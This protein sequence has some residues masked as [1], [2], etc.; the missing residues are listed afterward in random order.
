MRLKN[1]LAQFA[2]G[3]SNGFW[4]SRFFASAAERAQAL[5]EFMALRCSLVQTLRLDTTPSPQSRCSFSVSR[6]PQ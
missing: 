1:R 4:G 6:L 2:V 5:L 3:G